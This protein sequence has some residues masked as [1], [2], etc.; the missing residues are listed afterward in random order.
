MLQGI[1]LFIAR[2]AVLGKFGVN[3]SQNLYNSDFVESIAATIGLANAT[4][5]LCFN[6]QLL[7]D[8]AGLGSSIRLDLTEAIE[9]VHLELDSRAST[10]GE[11]LYYPAQ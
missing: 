11:C 10:P 9:I 7:R 3:L 6:L 8:Q 1:A 4:R 5:R 2:P